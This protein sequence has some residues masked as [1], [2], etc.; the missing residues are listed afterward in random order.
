MKAISL[1]TELD[2]RLTCSKSATPRLK[3]D[4]DSGWWNLIGAL[5]HTR[6]PCELGSHGLLEYI[7]N[8]TVAPDV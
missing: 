5:R 8:I 7:D 6:A 2:N 3:L 1:T 4:L